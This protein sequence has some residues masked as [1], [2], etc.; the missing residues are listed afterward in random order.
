[1]LGEQMRDFVL[2]KVEMSEFRG[3]KQMRF[4]HATCM[5]CRRAMRC[6]KFGITLENADSV[7]QMWAAPCYSLGSTRI[8]YATLDG[9]LN[10]V[11]DGNQIS[12]VPLSRD[13]RPQLALSIKHLGSCCL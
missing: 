10:Y 1:V 5:T 9:W 4:E 7:L 6:Q 13:F 8:Y 2:E 11:C 12:R 3:R